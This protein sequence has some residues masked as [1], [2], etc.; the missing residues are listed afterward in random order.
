MRTSKRNH[1]IIIAAAASAIAAAF[2]GIG[3]FARRRPTPPSIMEYLVKFNPQ[4]F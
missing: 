3:L 4:G 1:S 2:V